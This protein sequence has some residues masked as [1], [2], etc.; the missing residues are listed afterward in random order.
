MQKLARLFYYIFAWHLPTQPMPGWRLGYW[1]RGH[2]VKKIFAYCGDDVIIKR[3][4]YFGTGQHIK[5]GHRSQ[6]GHCCRID[7]DVEI[8]NDVM[9]GPDVVMMTNSHET[10]RLD[11]PM[12]AQGPS[13]RKA[14]HVGNDVWIG[15]RVIILPGVSIG[16]GAIVAAGSVV[17][18]DVPAF[19]VVAG[20]PARL[21]KYRNGN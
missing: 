13:P 5:L 15:T 17:T 6:L 4:A 7:N 16:D 2:L 12:I 3:R 14:I 19:A 21:I 11:V 20:V 10:S 9:M 18:R 8:G 1:L